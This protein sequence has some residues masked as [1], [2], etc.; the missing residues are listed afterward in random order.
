VL[1]EETLEGV[2]GSQE[3]EDVDHLFEVCA[4]NLVLERLVLAE[5]VLFLHLLVNEESKVAGAGVW[6]QVCAQEGIVGLSHSL[7]DL[8]VAAKGLTQDLVK[9][10]FEGY[11]LLDA[12]DYGN[13]LVSTSKEELALVP[14]VSAEV[15]SEW[16]QQVRV[17]E[18]AEHQPQEVDP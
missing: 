1:S 17:G 12:C 16:L 13:G 5:R 7:L 9:Q 8:V 3:S 14:Y 15:V 11:Q 18:E 6:L 10:S 4:S 2:L